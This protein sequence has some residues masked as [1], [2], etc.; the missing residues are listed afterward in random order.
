MDFGL[1]EEQE[2]L[3]GSAREFLN[4]ECSVGFVR[5]LYDDAEGFSHQLH[6][7][8]AELGWAG[9]LIPEVY[10]GL[11]LG[12]LD[13]AVLLEEMGRAAVPGPFLFSSVLTTLALMQGGTETQKNSWLPRF[14]AGEAIG[15]VAF[16]EEGDRLDARGVRLK[17]EKTTEGYTLFGTKMFV[18]YASVSDVLL[19]AARTMI[20]G[21]QPDAGVSLFLVER[22]TLGLAI[23]PDR[24][25][26]LSL[27]EI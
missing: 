25:I 21:E 9:V 12:M 22:G 3:Q 16:L 24:N 8:M 2:L 6:H 17:A 5:D 14:A 27:T 10:H 4:Q 20:E 7:K 15:S 26:R 18:P 23:K 13:M 11:G 1:S 19:V